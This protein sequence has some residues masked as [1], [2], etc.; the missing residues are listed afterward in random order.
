MNIADRIDDSAKRNPHAPALEIRRGKDFIRYTFKDLVEAGGRYAQTLQAAKVLPGSRVVLICENRPELFVSIYTLFH[1][2]LTIV[3][4]DPTLSEAETSK[5]I[6]QSDPQAIVVTS[7]TASKLKSG[8]EHLPVFLADRDYLPLESYASSAKPVSD[9]DSDIAFILFT[10]GTTSQ[11]KGVMLEHSAVMHAIEGIDEV[12]PIKRGERMVQILPVFHIAPLTCALGLL[13]H[14]CGM[15]FLEKIEGPIIA[16]AMADVRPKQQ[17]VVPRLLEFF[18]QRITE[19]VRKQGPSKEKA[20]RILLKS[21][22]YLNKHARINLGPILF[23]KVHAIFGGRVE[24]MVSGGSALSAETFLFFE[25]MG[26]K[27]SEG[28]GLTET[29][30]GVTVNAPTHRVSG[31]VGKAVKDVQIRILGDQDGRGQEG[32]ILIKSPSLMRGYFRDPL[33]TSE[34]IRDGWFHTGDLGRLDLDNNLYVTGRAKEMIVTSGGKKMSPQLIESHYQDIAGLKEL[35]V[36]GLAKEGQNVDIIAAFVVLDEDARTSQGMTEEEQLRMAERQI[37]E[38]A[39]QL[40]FHYRIQQVRQV[41]EIP[42]TTLGKVKR[43]ELRKNAAEPLTLHAKPLASPDASAWTPQERRLIE[44]VAGYCED[45]S[46]LMDASLSE[47]GLD[48]LGLADIEAF[49]ESEFGKS[50]GRAELLNAANLRSLLRS[51]ASRERSSSASSA[52]EKARLT[53]VDLGLRH[54]RLFQMISRLSSMIWRTEYRGL[55]NIPKTGHYILIANHESH[56]DPLWIVA[57]LPDFMR[58][59]L[60]TLSKKEHWQHPLTRM[61]AKM[62]GGIPVDREGDINHAMEVAAQV[63]R[64]QGSLLLFPEGTRT[65]DGAMKPFKRGVA[66]LALETQTPILPISIKGAYQI[67][68]AHRRMPSFYY[69]RALRRHSLVISFG[70][71]VSV[72]GMNLGMQAEFELMAQLEEKVIQLSE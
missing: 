18:Q 49:I 64:K 30:G 63:L 54:R 48:S 31:S 51:I 58:D 22:L 39:S 5:L 47:L 20:F 57:T 21:S 37:R 1:S 12:V 23:K 68:P 66:K 46:R 11:P 24:N 32:E 15:Q 41:R 9:G 44:M 14:G 61:G 65:R 43:H 70:P 71:V 52:D 53:P 33:Q 13:F 10:S 72:S 6:M 26:F 16:A 67:F 17:L 36:T 45:K 3:L 7:A 27:V 59:R 42:K 69:W 8:F 25:S 19:E 28:Y 34:A 29:S 62:L 4:L 2:R 60:C 38:R 55:E 35:A 56:L 50:L 40:L